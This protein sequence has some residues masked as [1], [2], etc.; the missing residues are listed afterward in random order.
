M[1]F[2][3]HSSSELSSNLASLIV[4]ETEFAFDVRPFLSEFMSG[5]EFFCELRSVTST[6]MMQWYFRLCGRKLDETP[7][8]Q[9]G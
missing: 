4:A 1:K 6:L 7:L 9:W 8:C 3:L 5:E 2:P